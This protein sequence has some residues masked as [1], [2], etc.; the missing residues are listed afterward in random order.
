[1]FE[2]NIPEEEL[3]KLSRAIAEAIFKSKDVKKIVE[4]IR[5]KDLILPHAL[6]V[7]IL[8]LETLSNVK[9]DNQ[10]DAKSLKKY[11]NKKEK[12]FKQFIDGRELDTNEIAFQEYLMKR[13]D[14][15]KWLKKH[16]LIF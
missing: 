15:K 1:V 10:N 9:G 4:E 8:K 12:S 16:G 6:M 5:K 2:K 3:E 13:F 7:L 11:L 14:D